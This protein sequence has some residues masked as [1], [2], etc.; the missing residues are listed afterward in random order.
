MTRA[1][2]GLKLSDILVT[3][4]IAVVF[5]IIY[6]VWHF[7]Y[8]FSKISGLHVEEIVYGMWFMAA[9]VAYLIIPKPGIAI[10]AEFAAGAGETIVMG[11]FDVPTMI[12]GLLQGIACEV[13]FL[14]FRYK[15]R[16]AAVAMLAGLMAAIITLPL[17]FAYGY[18]NELS[19]WNLT[20][21]IVFRLIGGLL[22]AGLL[23]YYIVKALDQTGVTKLFRPAS[24]KDYDNL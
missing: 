16:S 7:V 18:L 17:D 24:K 12:Y 20:L 14:I 2:R 8:D 22:V 21:Y 11:R 3:V 5:A 23:S 13:I 6:N 9:V 10:L 15:S 1:S 19:G 4:L